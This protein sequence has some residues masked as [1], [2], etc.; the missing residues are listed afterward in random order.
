[1][2]VRAQPLSDALGVEISGLD[3]TRPLEQDTAV[4]LRALLDAHQ[5]LLFRGQDI[6]APDQ[7]RLLAIFGKVSD[8]S[9]DGTLHNFVSNVLPN[10]LFGEHELIFHSDFAFVDY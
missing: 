7:I 5:L 9:G 6:A 3:L 1:M 2:T 8:E 10:G 4:Q